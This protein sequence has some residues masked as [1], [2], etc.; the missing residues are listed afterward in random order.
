[1]KTRYQ[2]GSSVIRLHTGLILLL[3][4]LYAHGQEAS[5]TG[6]QGIINHTQCSAFIPSDAV[7]TANLHLCLSS[8]RGQAEM[9]ACQDLHAQSGM[10]RVYFK[11]GRQPKAIARLDSRN[12]VSQLVWKENAFTP[13]PDCKLTTPP[14]IFANS[15]FM[16][17]S[18]CEDDNDQSVPCA[19]FRVQAPRVETYADYMIFYGP[20]GHGPKKIQMVYTGVNQDAIPAELMYQ[21]GLSLIHTRCCQQSGLQYIQQASR[22]FPTSRLYRAAYQHYKAEIQT[23]TLHKLSSY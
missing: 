19:V 3:G 13:S 16:G 14:R 8:H 12:Q 10:F 1:M 20:K 2:F 7:P 21:I 23:H 4:A 18:V 5:L 17:A 11:G 6:P 22:L 15:R 9:Y